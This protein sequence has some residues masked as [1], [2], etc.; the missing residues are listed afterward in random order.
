[1]FYL[2]SSYPVL[3]VFWCCTD[4]QQMIL[5]QEIY[6]LRETLDTKNN[7]IEHLQ[8]KVHK[9]EKSGE[10]DLKVSSGYIT[11]TIIT[12]YLYAW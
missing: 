8:G 11:M 9:L 1:M 10:P 7:I 6:N 12:F 2:T 4:E 3:M 5:E